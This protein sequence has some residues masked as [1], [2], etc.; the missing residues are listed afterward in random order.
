M[1]PESVHQQ[2][3]TLAW[4]LRDNHSVQIKIAVTD[5]DPDVFMPLKK[6]HPGAVTSLQTTH[7]GDQKAAFDAMELSQDTQTNFAHFDACVTTQRELEDF[8]DLQ[9]R[10]GMVARGSVLFDGM[11]KKLWQ[12]EQGNALWFRVKASL[13]N[14]DAF[15]HQFRAV[16][17]IKWVAK[18]KA[19]ACEKI[20]AGKS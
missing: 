20:A 2:L 8:L 4:L 11:L 18:I 13:A 16:M 12:S 15:K 6:L 10:A 14:V 17:D 9:K 19:E 5:Y 1:H 7:N 3:L